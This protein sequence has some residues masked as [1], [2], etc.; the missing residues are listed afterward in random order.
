VTNILV[1][2]LIDSISVKLIKRKSDLYK[3]PIQVEEILNIMKQREKGNGRMFKNTNDK[4]SKMTFQ[5]L[6][7]RHYHTHK[8]KLIDDIK[9]FA[10]KVVTIPC[11]Y[12]L[13]SER[14]GTLL[15]DC[16]V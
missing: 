12:S 4:I 2:L 13:K 3:L 10:P 5:V 9:N 8:E 1:I 11:C 16:Q 6:N 15:I 14:G 7:I